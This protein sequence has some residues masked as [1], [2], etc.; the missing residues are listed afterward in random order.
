MRLLFAGGR[1]H[2]L[3]A[4]VRRPDT[5][6]AGVVFAQPGEE[7]ILVTRVIGR[8]VS[9]GRAAVAEHVGLVHELG[10][11]DRHAVIPAQREDLF[12]LARVPGLLHAVQARA[13]CNRDHELRADRLAEV[14]HAD[15]L[16]FGQTVEIAFGG[17]AG[18]VEIIVG[19]AGPGAGYPHPDRAK[20]PGKLAQLFIIEVDRRV[21]L[22]R[23]VRID[24]KFGDGGN[25]LGAGNL[26]GGVGLP[27]GAAGDFG[28]LDVVGHQPIID[29][30]QGLQLC[31]GEFDDLGHG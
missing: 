28:H 23:A 14:Q 29:G 6:A 31:G 16:L 4:G 12:G 9:F 19:F 7:E 1:A 27:E 21:H 11:I 30:A 8:G 24:R 18:A 20:I 22:H 17:D 2:R 26:G 10:R 13:V 5:K 25:F 3:V 15:P